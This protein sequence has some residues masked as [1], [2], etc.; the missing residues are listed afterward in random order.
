[1]YTCTYIFIYTERERERDH[2]GGVSVRLKTR[3]VVLL[4]MPWLPT[5][6][7]ITIHYTMIQ[8]YAILCHIILYNII[9][10]IISY[11]II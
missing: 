3:A 4:S 7:V 10:H 6:G 8:Y 5:N 11:Y 2:V 1:M 9:L